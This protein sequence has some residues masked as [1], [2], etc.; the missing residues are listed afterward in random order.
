MAALLRK[1]EFELPFERARQG[2]FATI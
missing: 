2:I 1:Y